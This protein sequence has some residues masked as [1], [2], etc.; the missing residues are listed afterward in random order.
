MKVVTVLQLPDY[1]S[2]VINSVSGGTY[3]FDE[4]VKT[5]TVTSDIPEPYP[6]GN[7]EATS[8]SVYIRCE[9]RKGTEYIYDKSFEVSAPVETIEIRNFDELKT[10]LARPNEYTNIEI[11]NDVTITENTDI[12]FGKCIEVTNGRTLTIADGSALS[13]L[14]GGRFPHAGGA[15]IGTIK[16]YAGGDY[17]KNTGGGHIV[18]NDDMSYIQYAETGGASRTISIEGT[19]SVTSIS[20]FYDNIIIPNGSVLNVERDFVLWLNS[21]Q[22]LT[23][24]G[25]LNIEDDGNFIIAGK[26]LIESTATLNV[27][28]YG[29]VTYYD[30]S[31]FKIEPGATITGWTPPDQTVTVT[32]LEGFKGALAKRYV[33]SIS[34]AGDITLDGDYG[35]YDRRDLLITVNS[36][37]TLT[38]PVT[39][40]LALYSNLINNGTLTLADGASYADAHVDVNAGTLTNNGA[41]TIGAYGALSIYYSSDSGKFI[42]N[43]T[44]TVASNGRI[45]D[46]GVPGAFTNNSGTITGDGSWPGKN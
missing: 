13:V 11:R 14:N 41:F 3:V 1:D 27:S 15:V 35:T 5:L 4:T 25:I 40:S 34:I 21:P 39:G 23:I 30:N 7:F 44:V 38:I 33:K 18:A 32:D 31:D 20:T 29:I 45:Y 12:P 6:W 9:I 28:Q 26:A 16:V 17:K 19:A 24:A 10:A 36:G 46:Y 8:N 22:N 37:S 43:G 2:A 42:N